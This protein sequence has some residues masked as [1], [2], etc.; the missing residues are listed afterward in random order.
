METSRWFTPRF[1]AVVATSAIVLVS[2]EAPA[3]LVPMDLISV[4]DQLITLDTSTG[5]AW[6]D[7]TATMNLSVQDI[8]S[9]AGAW[10][11]RGFVYASSDQVRTLFLNADPGNVVINTGSD[12]TSSG[13]LLGAQRLL[14]LLGV[15]H[16]GPSGNEFDILGNGIVGVGEPGAGLAHFAVYGTNSDATVGYFF[17]PDGVASTS[18]KD[19]EVGSFLVLSPVP[20]ASQTW[21]FALGLPLV[22]L[23]ASARRRARPLQR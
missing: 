9:G 17:V 7:L 18:F 8:R 3:A 10:S 14:D 11:A 5:L 13:N 20:E 1:A 21:L 15:T 6:L 4:G 12:P 19:P 16:P 22:A 2:G 23:G